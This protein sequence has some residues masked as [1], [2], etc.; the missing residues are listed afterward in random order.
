MYGSADRG[1]D[2][3]GDGAV[4]AAEDPV[5]N[6]VRMQELYRGA[7]GAVVVGDDARDGGPGLTGGVFRTVGVGGGERG[8][9]AGAGKAR[10]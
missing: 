3:G 4:I 7:G 9:R 6:P 2:V 5:G 10:R 1:L 8:G